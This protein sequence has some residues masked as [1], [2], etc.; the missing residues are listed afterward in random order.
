MGFLL[1][2]AANALRHP[3]RLPPFLVR[4]FKETFLW[5]YYYAALPEPKQIAREDEGGAG[6]AEILA[7]LRD[8]G[9]LLVDYRLDVADFRAYRQRA[10]YE[11][12]PDYYAGGRAPYFPE[13][14]LEHYLAAKLLAL[15]ADDVYLDIASGRSPAADVYRQIVGCQTYRQDLTFPA[16]IKEARIGGDAARLPLPDA[17]AS[18]M[19]LHCSFEHFEGDTD[20]AFLRE[21]ARVLQPG[22]RLCILPL[23]LANRYVI[24]TDPVVFPR[25]GL[26]FDSDALIS[27]RKGYGNRFGRLYDVA[28]FL[29]RLRTNLGSLS[30]T[31]YV[32]QNETAV[33]EHCYLK[34][35]ALFEKTAMSTPTR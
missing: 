2:R 21:A 1:H 33:D 24:Y 11:R 23:Y 22:G 15:Q 20:I 5:H 9:V 14:A 29:S 35:A 7:Q 10:Q 12:F 34:L 28:H 32:I 25:S 6:L 19:A 17:F 31:I 16:G 18:K 26:A 30:L 4:K 27:A 3:Q 13:K 8:A